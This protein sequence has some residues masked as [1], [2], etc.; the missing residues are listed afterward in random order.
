MLKIQ[1]VCYMLTLLVSIPSVAA[2]TTAADTAKPMVYSCPP[3]NL[4]AMNAN[5]GLHQDTLTYNGVPYKVM[6]FVKDFG[7][8]YPPPQTF[9][10]AEAVKS[11]DKV[12]C[13]YMNVPS[14]NQPPNFSGGSGADMPINGSYGAGVVAP[15][16]NWQANDVTLSVKGKICMPIKSSYWVDGKCTSAPA[17]CQF[18]CK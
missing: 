15:S 13:K 6:A 9:T 2:V 17:N 16:D 18:T 7:P 3:A 12:L 5:L 11:P 8:V 4:P 14:P 1:N 10:G